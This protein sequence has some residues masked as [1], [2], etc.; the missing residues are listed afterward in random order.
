MRPGPLTIAAVVALVGGCGHGPT[1]R[2]RPE[3]ATEMNWR[4]VTAALPRQQIARAAA[5]LAP[6]ARGWATLSGAGQILFYRLTP[7]PEDPDL[8]VVDSPLR[9]ERL[10]T[11]N[12]HFLGVLAQNCE[13]GQDPDRCAART[14]LA[15]VGDPP[16]TAAPAELAPVELTAEVVA[17]PRCSTPAPPRAFTVLRSHCPSAGTGG[18][19]TCPVAPAPDGSYAIG[20]FRVLI[21]TWLAECIVPE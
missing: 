11:R 7:D 1:P 19:N 5:G 15:V 16:A 8:L 18:L 12:G 6:G 9:D 21:A 13:R 10:M 17:D 14:T 3:P 4:L 2:H 20:P